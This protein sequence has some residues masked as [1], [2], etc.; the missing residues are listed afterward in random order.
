MNYQLAVNYCN[1][2]ESGPR[3][4]MHSMAWKEG[5]GPICPSENNFPKKAKL[6]FFHFPSNVD[7][8][9]TSSSIN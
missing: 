4:G 1:I 5:G 2:S 8:S 6:A 3:H 9:L 7:F